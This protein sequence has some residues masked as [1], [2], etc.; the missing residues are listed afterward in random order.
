MS[1]IYYFEDDDKWRDKIA[2]FLMDKGYEV[3]SF[4][5]PHELK[6]RIDE[7]FPDLILLDVYFKFADGIKI[8]EE[9]LKKKYRVKV[10][11]ISDKRI[12]DDD[13][14]QGIKAGAVHYIK[15]Q[16]LLKDGNIDLDHLD[17]LVGNFFR[18]SSALVVDYTQKGR[19]LRKNANTMTIE[20]EGKERKLTRIP[21]HIFDYLS[22]NANIVRTMD[23]ITQ[24][25]SVILEKEVATESVKTHIL[26]IRK[27]IGDEWI[28]TEKSQSGYAFTCDRN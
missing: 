7:Q 22:N 8:V 6:A 9:L 23:Q 19:V 12:T 14:K 5:N 24:Y 13:L 18:P 25:I 10:M 11:F 28:K 26:G 27:K 20:V 17:H 15:K 3:K 21:W 1:L 4:V 16:L 2:A